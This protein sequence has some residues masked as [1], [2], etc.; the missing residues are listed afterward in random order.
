MGLGLELMM[1]LTV[2]NFYFLVRGSG[3]RSLLKDIP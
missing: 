3:A 1:L 2:I